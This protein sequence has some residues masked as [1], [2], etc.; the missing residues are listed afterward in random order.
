MGGMPRL[1]TRRALRDDSSSIERARRLI[2]R[3]G[4]AV[5]P[6]RVRLSVEQGP[7]SAEPIPVR[8]ALA[9]SYT[10]VAVGQRW[11]SPWWTT[12]FRLSGP[13]P[14]AWAGRRVQRKISTQR[15][16]S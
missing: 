16:S 7:V 10:P 2:N 6:Q 14:V 11:G 3:L 9:A 4:S 5:Y 13:V 1:W 12:W 15:M 8:E